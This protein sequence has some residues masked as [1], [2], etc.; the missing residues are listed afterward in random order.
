MSTKRSGTPNRS[1]FD[2]C[3]QP[4]T[5]IHS[6]SQSQPLPS[7]NAAVT[8]TQKVP[9]IASTTQSRR[10]RAPSDP[11]LDTPALSTSCSTA[12][13]TAHL[14]SSGSF[15]PEEPITPTSQVYDDD[16]FD[17]GYSR[18]EFSD[19]DGYM[20]TWIFPD[21][22]DP[23]IHSLLRLFPAFVTRHPLPRFTVSPSPHQSLLQD[24]E[25]GKV[26]PEERKI[27]IGTGG[28]WLGTRVRTSG[29]E[30][31]WWTRF[32]LWWRSLFC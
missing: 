15:G 7:N 6:R 26:P 1:G 25:T 27:K 14:S 11:F 10:P 24:I 5:T 19:S 31:G 28:M 23:E 32:I 4:L 9:P 3:S 16:Q 22:T 21:L 13:T 8:R 18:S 20:R 17:N 2:S 29:W 30:G 12:N